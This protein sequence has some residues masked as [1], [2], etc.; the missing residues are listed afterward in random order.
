MPRGISLLQRM[1]NS[2]YWARFPAQTELEECKRFYLGGH[3]YPLSDEEVTE[4][5]NA[6]FGE[7]IS[8]YIPPGSYGWGLYGAGNYGY[9]EE[10]M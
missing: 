9:G 5:T 6:G 3:V 2:Y 4:L 1:D 10:R 8:D 7:Y